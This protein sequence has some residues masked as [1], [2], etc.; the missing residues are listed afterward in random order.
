MKKI[1]LVLGVVGMLSCQ[2]VCYAEPEPLTTEVSQ[3]SMLDD[4]GI[5]EYMFI[6]KSLWEEESESGD[7]KE[8]VSEMLLNFFSTEGI[9]EEG[10]TP[11]DIRNLIDDAYEYGFSSDVLRLSMDMLCEE[12]QSY[13]EA[14]QKVFH[15][16]ALTS[17]DAEY[18]LLDVGDFPEA[19]LMYKNDWYGDRTD[20]ERIALADSIL[21]ILEAADVDTCGY[22]GNTMAQALNDLYDEDAGDSVLYL[23]LDTLGEVELYPSVIESIVLGIDEAF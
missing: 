5:L 14:V 20:D 23:I 8:S 9:I 18:L 4:Y 1:L 15:R 13:G 16:Q 12:S 7:V 11:E 19:A 17:E 21:E 10:Y 3:L 6:G 2:T 22:D